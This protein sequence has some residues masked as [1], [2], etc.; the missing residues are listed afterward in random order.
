MSSIPSCIS[1]KNSL[2]SLFLGLIVLNLKQHNPSRLNFFVSHNIIKNDYNFNE[3]TRTVIYY[4][5]YMLY[6]SKY[7]NID[8][9][10]NIP[11]H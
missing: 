7:I 6:F 9:K 5:M 3:A 11:L 4:T 2:I 8:A 1:L 10:I